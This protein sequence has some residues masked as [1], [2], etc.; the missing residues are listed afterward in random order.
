MASAA[1]AKVGPK[2]EVVIPK[3]LRR[4]AKLKV[5]DFLRA[6]LRSNGILLKPAV[7]EQVKFRNELERHLR[8]AEQ[9]RK[10]GLVYGPFE[11]AEELLDSLHKGVKRLRKRS[12]RRA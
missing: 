9:D 4:A 2:F 6:E 5:G 3:E 10:R 7:I 8:E 12:R 11:S 1:T